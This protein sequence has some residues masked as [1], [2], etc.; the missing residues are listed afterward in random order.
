LKRSPLNRKT[1]LT[2]RAKRPSKEYVEA[3]REILTRSDG[4]CE[5]RVD[6]VCV[7]AAHHAHH[8]LRRSQGGSDDAS[9]LLAV[10]HQCHEWIHTHP[11]M[12]LEAEFL[13][14]PNSDNTMPDEWV[15]TYNEKPWTQNAERRMSIH[16]AR[17][18]TKRWRTDFCLLAKYMKIPLL[19]SAKICVIPYQR[20]GRLQDVAACYPAAKA[21][22]DGLVDAGVLLDDS[23]QFLTSVEFSAPERGDDKLVMVIYGLEEKI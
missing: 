18:L 5:A 6:G 11:A 22:I 9:N 2:A 1:P 4:A 10:C 19:K 21:A 20:L 13:R 15:I 8:M 3:K 16:D 7:G 17:K 14:S 12:A 23:S